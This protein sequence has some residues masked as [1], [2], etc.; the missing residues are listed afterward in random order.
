MS[1]SSRHSHHSR[2]SGSHA[3]S[4]IELQRL[5]QEERE[6]EEREAERQRNEEERERER[7]ADE[8]ERRRKS[9][10][11]ERQ[12]RA[13]EREEERIRKQKEDEAE[14][15]RRED[16]RE[17]QRREDERMRQREANEAI[18]RV[19]LLE[20]FDNNSD[21]GSQ[22]VSEPL[23]LRSYTLPRCDYSLP[24]KDAF[25]A[26]RREAESRTASGR[27]SPTVLGDTTIPPAPGMPHTFPPAPGTPHTPHRAS[28]VPTAPFH[29][30]ET[31]RMPLQTTGMPHG[32]SMTT[33]GSQAP[34]YRSTTPSGPPLH[35]VTPQVSVTP[36]AKSHA[37]PQYLLT[38]HEPHAIQ[39]AYE[40]NG[41]E[42]QKQFSSTPMVTFPFE[43]AISKPERDVTETPGN[44]HTKHGSHL[45]AN[46]TKAIEDL[47]QVIRDQNR[48]TQL[49]PSSLEKFDGDVTKFNKFV[50]EYE[51]I[52]AV[53]TDDFSK[54]LSHLKNHLIGTPRKLIEGCFHLPPEQGY[55][56]AWQRLH[57]KYSNPFQHQEAYLK[58]LLDFKNIGNE[59]IQAL[60]GYGALMF[61]VYCALQ[62]NT[63]RLEGISNINMF[64]S[65]LPK[66]MVIKWSKRAI[67]PFTGVPAS[68]RDLIDFIQHE[69]KIAENTR[70]ILSLTGASHV[71]KDKTIDKG[72]KTPSKETTLTLA[73][74][75]P[76]TSTGS[77]KPLMYYKCAFC[78]ESGHKIQ[79]CSVF[80]ALSVDERWD[81]VSSNGICYRCLTK[82]S[83]MYKDCHSTKRC[84]TCRAWYHH[85]LLHRAKKD[86]DSTE[87]SSDKSDTP[88]EVAKTP[89][90]AVTKHDSRSHEDSALPCSSMISTEPDGSVMLKILP[91]RVGDTSTYAFIDSGCASTLCSKSLTSRLGMKGI[92]VH[93]TMRTENG[94]FVCKELL[95]L[96]LKAVNEDV[97]LP[98]EEVYVTDAISVTTGHLMPIGW[99]GK[100]S[101]LDGI[102]VPRLSEDHKVEM[103][104]GLN[105]SLCR[106]ILELRAGE[107][108]EPTAYR[109]KLGWVVFGPTGPKTKNVSALPLYHIHPSPELNEVVQEHFSRDF[110][111]RENESKTEYS[112]DDKDFLA[113]M[114]AS[115]S[116]D[117]DKYMISLPFKDD[118]RYPDNRGLAE[119]RLACL[120]RKLEKD[121]AFKESYTAQM[122][123]LIDRGHAE[124]VPGSTLK[125]RDGKVWLIPH[126]SVM[127]PTKKKP[128]VV[129]DLK[130][131]HRGVSPNDHLLQGPDLTNTLVGVLL[132]FREGPIAVSADIEQMFYQ[133]RVPKD[134]RDMLRFL[135]WP[136][137][138]TDV[139]PKEYRL[140][141]HPFGA[142]SS[143]AC[144]NYALRKTAEDFGNNFNIR[145]SEALMNNFY[146]DNLLKA[147]FDEESCI[148]FVQDII[149][150][151]KMGGFRLNQWMSNSKHVL[152]SI[153]T[154]ERD[155]SVSSLDLY[156]DDLPTERALGVH[157]ALN[158]D[159]FTFNV[160]IKVKP[161]TKR[162]VLSTVAGNYDPLGLV[163]PFTMSAKIVL[164]DICRDKLDW[165]EELSG[166][167]LRKWKVWLAQ[168]GD[169]SN[170]R[171]PRNL[172]PYPFVHG[173]S[174]QL[175][176]FADASEK[177]YGVVSYL[178]SVNPDGKVHCAFV[179]ARARVAPLKDTTITR[180]ELTGA[181]VAVRV[182]QKL[183]SEI[184]I[185]LEPSQF[186]TDSTAVL[187]Y[188]YNTSARYQTFVANRVSLIREMSDVHDWHY[189]DSKSNIADI[190]SRGASVDELLSSNWTR[191]PSFPWKESTEWPETPEDVRAGR[192]DVNAEVKRLPIPCV[193]VTSQDSF[194]SDLAGRF[195]SWHKFQRCVTWML[196]FVKNLKAKVS[197][198][199]NLVTTGHITIGELRN[200]ETLIW[201]LVQ[202]G[203]YDKEIRCL[204]QRKP[205][206]LPKTSKIS[207]LK[208]ILVDGLLR[209]GGRL[210]RVDSRYHTTHPVILPP[211]APP[212]QLLVRSKHEL[213]GHCGRNH[214]LSILRDKYWV[215]SGNSAIK[216][217]TKGCVTC[218]KL[219]AKPMQQEMAEL[220]EDR[221]TP[222]HPP[223]TNTGADCFGPFVIRKGRTDH[224]R[225]G[226][227]FTCLTMRAVHIEVLENMTTDSFI[228]ALRRFVARRGAVRC[229]RS[230]NGSNLVGAEAELK[231]SL[232]NLDESLI[233]RS[234]AKMDIEWYFNP[235]H[236]SH[237]GG[238]W[239]R[240]IRSTRRV[241]A[242]I[243]Q[244]QTLSEENLVTL[245]CEAEAIING[246][247]LT[248]TSDDPNDL[249]PITPAHIL[250][251]KCPTG[252][253]TSTDKKDLY[254]RQK[255]RQVQYLADLF[256]TRWTK[257]YRPMLQ[258]RQKWLDPAKNAQ[259]G[260]IVLLVDESL[261]RGSW[262]LGRVVE[263][264][265]DRHGLVRK[266]R[267]R[268]QLGEYLRPIHKLC[269]ILE[270]DTK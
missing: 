191:G 101:H 159:C 110:C 214:L 160:K 248:R 199:T 267:I 238:A 185:Q 74:A 200:A 220:P 103:I 5:F 93:Q 155:V 213:A 20:I 9:D 211:R 217:A 65:K 216:Q 22:I 61:N 139:Q 233:A 121:A 68:F 78:S 256:W 235:P 64:A 132:R 88:K 94:D 135:W 222:G 120:K 41:G 166:D 48:I 187:K 83:H 62:P 252:P 23:P 113:K 45:I 55:Q 265:P 13:E 102:E 270:S 52:I 100:W 243:C 99:I 226:L 269:L 223:F 8:R 148:E 177:G 89:G 75:H 178:R 232:K 153:P 57:A 82:G 109:T 116:R 197:N 92:P 164:Q 181:S 108:H 261:G 161:A 21:M 180:L 11:L 17:A 140:T 136:G 66:H 195:S 34:R 35:P 167:H 130:A 4:A 59:D 43:S 230:D 72:K 264:F 127:H 125:R 249:T 192:L 170:F 193:G 79:Q 138:D 208:P 63:G 84:D 33:G 142:K 49:P 1:N 144:V 247:P 250:T 36:S 237:F 246:R 202:K 31:N 169:L 97:T 14:Y 7:R 239:E 111:E 251:L 118:T 119:Q 47:T 173:S 186:W 262:P 69:V 2:R 80:K 143:P 28:L 266:A 219:A 151:C 3:A 218:K 189:V 90:K 145:A 124:L 128:R 224:K 175:H 46:D 12:R 42:Q 257:E 53:N 131:K 73:A 209:V 16:A 32:T 205:N 126:F 18:R 221:I 163:A 133:V 85:T 234:M 39:N 227:I 229:I 244:H 50:R 228:N 207:R 129:F 117:N 15:Q 71:T 81:Y 255:W 174:H 259:I 141:V 253:I 188:I 171:I 122:E 134:D 210:D 203:D 190:A 76:V 44:V 206:P 137:G 245:M 19:R 6:A 165:D 179:M 182:D 236:A 56:L 58:Q 105:S 10:E 162:G 225:Y 242:G 51:W 77:A 212:V 194:I 240:M 156:R 254:V 149:S 152:S 24:D 154:T 231:R 38:P 30:P 87:T 114:A 204:Q 106:N 176:H 158:D 107:E 40:Q 104:I 95:S 112:Q 29:R 263:V 115:I 183:R 268:T 168:L 70:D 146:V 215:V 91:V 25:E 258:D 86:T 96:K 147:T 60:E 54:R 98:I 26:W 241:L 172:I 201:E 198:S 27:L 196:R 260:D 37:P 67:D 150:L 184:Q 157:W 123:K